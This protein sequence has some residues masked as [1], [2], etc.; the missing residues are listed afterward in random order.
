MGKNRTL[1]INDTQNFILKGS[2]S[3]QIGIYLLLFVFILKSLLDGFL[4]DV[5]ML[6]MMSIEI[7]E[8]AAF[9]FISLFILLS[10]LAVLFSNRRRTRRAGY[11][12]MNKKTFRQF[13][14]YLG[15]TLPA[16]LIIYSIAN[17]GYSMFAGVSFLFLLGTIL[18]GLNSSKKK[19]L[20][21]LSGLSIGLAVIS[22]LIPS[23][24]YSSIL[25]MGGAFIVYG[26][27]IRK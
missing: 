5:S 9:I 27:M 17:G 7:I 6:G 15:W 21:I 3:I 2:N 10:G 8:L 22:Y 23:Y 20:Y 19:A 12:L 24:W 18:I 11:K 16:F 1:T 4:S 26:I 13:A 25:I 14:F